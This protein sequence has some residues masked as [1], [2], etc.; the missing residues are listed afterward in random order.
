MLKIKS[1]LFTFC[2]MATALS[3][4]NVDKILDKNM[5]VT[6]GEKSWNNLNS[7]ILKG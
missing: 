3:A 1:T 2:I 5:E 7:I 4:Q 6:G